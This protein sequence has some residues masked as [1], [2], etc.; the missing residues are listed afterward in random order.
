[1]AGGKIK[2]KQR[3]IGVFQDSY[4]VE[5]LV[6]RSKEEQYIF[7]FIQFYSDTAPWSQQTPP[8]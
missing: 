5:K 7:S 4:R 1:M 6:F 2:E 8:T 3:N